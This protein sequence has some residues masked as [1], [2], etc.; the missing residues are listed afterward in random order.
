M[1]I[2]QGSKRYRHGF[3]LVCILVFG[4]AGRASAWGQ[5]QAGQ[6]SGATVAEAAQPLPDR[7]TGNGPPLASDAVAE[8]VYQLEG[9]TVRKISFEGVDP[10]RLAPLPG[11]LPQAAGVPLSLEKLKSSLRELFATGQYEDI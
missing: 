7:D 9:L 2:G 11:Q 5:I 3:L 1:P 6:D 8:P 10:A 4:I